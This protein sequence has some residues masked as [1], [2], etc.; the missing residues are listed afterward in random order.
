MR[1]IRTSFWATCIVLLLSAAVRAQ[2]PESPLT[3]R[4]VGV[5]VSKKGI[6]FGSGAN[7]DL[8][9][10]VQNK[11]SLGLEAEALK[12]AFS[13][14]LGNALVQAL[15]E[16]QAAYGSFFVN[17]KPRYANLF[18]DDLPPKR[19]V[20]AALPPGA[21]YVLLIDQLQIKQETRRS[22]MVISNKMRSIRRTVE[23]LRVKLQL[24]DTFAG[25]V[26][27]V[28]TY[29]YDHEAKRD[30]PNYLPTLSKHTKSTVFL[31]HALNQGLDLLFTNLPE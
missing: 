16:D 5:Y 19:K 18:L 1:I 28:A 10:F 9:S 12:L 22:V 23:L 13:I 26:V 2:A 15:E 31:R 20:R 8:A 11:D 21:K 6:K 14:R 29:N 25:E 27:S 17:A 3:G 4:Q 24:Y 7:L 30:W